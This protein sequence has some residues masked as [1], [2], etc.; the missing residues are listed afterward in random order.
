MKQKNK[1]IKKKNLGVQEKNEGILGVIV[2][3]S[4]RVR[5]G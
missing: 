2:D 4:E 1:K 3:N 5:N